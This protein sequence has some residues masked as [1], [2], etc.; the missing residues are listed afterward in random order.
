MTT[1]NGLSPAGLCDHCGKQLD[2]DNLLR[3]HRNP[4]GRYCSTRCMADAVLFAEAIK[5]DQSR[6]A[7]SVDTEPSELAPEEKTLP[8]PTIEDQVLALQASLGEMYTACTRAVNQ[9]GVLL[10]LARENERAIKA[11]VAA[12]EA[13]EVRVARIESY[14]GF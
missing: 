5:S 7:V 9:V 11:E 8:P 1:I 10:Q 4:T 12:R 6:A 3:N 13:L 14:L 2:A